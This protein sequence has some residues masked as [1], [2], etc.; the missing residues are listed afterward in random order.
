[1]GSIIQCGDLST[2]FGSVDPFNKNRISTT[3]F[4]PKYID[5]TIIYDS[6]G[7]II[8]TTIRNKT[9]LNNGSIVYTDDITDNKGNITRII[10]DN[11]C[12][13]NITCTKRYLDQYFGK[14]DNKMWNFINNHKKK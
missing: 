13:T 5:K 12:G 4:H 10:V 11:K 8:S 1:M 7:N 9:I 2:L 3:S 6:K 14:I